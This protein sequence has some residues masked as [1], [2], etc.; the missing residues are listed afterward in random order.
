MKRRALVLTALAVAASVALVSS[1]KVLADEPVNDTV[2]FKNVKILT[3]VTSKSEMRRIMKEQAAALGVKCSH[4]H[5]PGKFDLDEKKEKVA[6]R[7]MMKMVRDINALPV[8][9]DAEEKPAVTC[10]TCHRGGTE[11]E[12]VVPQSA[13]DKLD[14]QEGAPPAGK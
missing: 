3:G 10:W 9:K 7:E 13:Y 2:Q 12:H 6:A 8:F 14:S 11:P 5:V 1:R 4:C